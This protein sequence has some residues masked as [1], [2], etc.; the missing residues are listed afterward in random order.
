MSSPMDIDDSEGAS[1]SETTQFSDDLRSHSSNLSRLVSFI[2]GLTPGS[3]NQQEQENQNRTRSRD[4]IV[5]INPIAQRMLIIEGLGNLEE[6][7]SE[8]S[9]KS[10]PK[11]A[12]QDSIDSMPVVEINKVNGGDCAICLDEFSIGEDAREMPCKHKYHSGCI[13]KWLGI[14]GSCPVCRFR[15]PE[16]KERKENE[17]EGE[18][19]SR[20][21]IWFGFSQG[22]L[23]GSDHDGPGSDGGN[24]GDDDGASTVEDMDC[25]D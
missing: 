25:T 4:R 13:Q 15:M 5:I 16:E 24:E 7:L 21:E 17:E 10:G 23:H 12:S 11:P 20:V 14:H 2:L 22:G 19:G 8:M 9:G 3:D 6:Y 18:G 1:E